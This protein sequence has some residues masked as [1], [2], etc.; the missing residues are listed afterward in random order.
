MIMMVA[1]LDLSNLSGAS[2]LRGTNQSDTLIG[3]EQDNTIF[4]GQEITII[5]LPVQ[6]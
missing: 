2:N 5:L 6:G 3:N 4:F 1:T